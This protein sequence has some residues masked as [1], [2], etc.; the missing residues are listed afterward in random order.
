MPIPD[1]YSFEQAA[2][3]P[4]AAMTAWQVGPPV[5][6]YPGDGAVMWPK[7][8]GPGFGFHRPT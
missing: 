1:G 3:V 8:Q 7:G 6:E 2:A 4:L 5:A